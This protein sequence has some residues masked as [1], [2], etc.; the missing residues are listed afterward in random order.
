MKRI[1][2]AVLFIML[3]PAAFLYAADPSDLDSFPIAGD[4]DVT[5]ARLVLG[6]DRWIQ[7]HF[8]LQAGWM[9]SKTWD[10][11][12]GE[13]RHDSKWQNDAFIRSCRLIFNGQFASNVYFYVAT[14]DLKAGKSSAADKD[15]NSD[16]GKTNL[17]T[18]DA[19]IKFVANREFQIYAGLLTVPLSRQNLQ[20]E[21]TL[22]G[23]E[24]NPLM[25]GMDGYSNNGRD[26]GL[27]VRGFIPFLEYRVGAFRGF[28]RSKDSEITPTR[29][30]HDY[31]RL[32]ARVQ[33]SAGDKE[34]GYFYSENYLGKRD[35]IAFG[36]GI[37]YQ[38]D[39]GKHKEDYLSYAADV[40]FETST[41]FLGKNAITA[42]AG[43]IN[44]IYYPVDAKV[45]Y[46]GFLAYYL[47]LGMLFNDSFQ[48]MARFTYRK[49]TGTGARKYQTITGG[50]NYFINGH[51]ANIRLGVDIPI[52]KNK[53]YEDQYKG[54]LQFQGYL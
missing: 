48:P 12:N 26:T 16:T 38:P 10:S 37:D 32:A 5:K 3:I 49:E 53:K 42:Q 9:G 36:A 21:A 34:E 15:E 28:G 23:V 4:E 31:P 51:Y 45:T 47:Q 40:S 52:G 24:R 30:K 39:V 17:Y 44:S 43:V 22:L 50:I 14:D 27:M 33:A 46:D 18:Q 1:T 20:S 11:A 41:D 7:P 54:V 13:T 2:T 19:Y 29:N 6:N 8:F 25:R 35:V